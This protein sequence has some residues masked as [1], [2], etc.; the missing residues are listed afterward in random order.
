VPNQRA[1]SPSR[2]EVGEVLLVVLIAHDVVA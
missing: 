1:Q 2:L